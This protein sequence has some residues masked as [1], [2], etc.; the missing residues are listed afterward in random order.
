MSRRNSEY[1]RTMD[2]IERLEEEGRITVIR[3]LRP[4]EVDR[5]EKDTDKL[6][7]LY[8]EGYAIAEELLKRIS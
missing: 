2:L 3:P 5:M 7:A 4:V 8:D 1:N 6:R